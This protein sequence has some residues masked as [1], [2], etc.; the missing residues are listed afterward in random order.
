MTQ[1]KTLTILCGET[2]VQ[3]DEALSHNSKNLL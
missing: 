3:T 2:A 1:P